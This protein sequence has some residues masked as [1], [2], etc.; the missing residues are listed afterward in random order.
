MNGLSTKRGV[1]LRPHD[2]GSLVHKPRVSINAENVGRDRFRRHRSNQ[3][4][5]KPGHLIINP[6][7]GCRKPPAR[8]CGAGPRG[9]LRVIP[10]PWLPV[11]FLIGGDDRLDE[12]VTHDIRVRSRRGDRQS[13]GRFA[14]PLDGIGQPADRGGGE[15][16]LTGDHPSRRSA[17]FAP[18]ASGT[19]S[20]AG[21][22]RSAPHRG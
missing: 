17:S 19:S 10:T 7:R 13:P 12:R 2:R 22:S 8:N 4:R 11:K 3:H 16:D 14:E 9:R 6:S 21:P 5:F 20:S 18:S 15:I 1:S